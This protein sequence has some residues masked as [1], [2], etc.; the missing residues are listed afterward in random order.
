V[1]SDGLKQLINTVTNDRTDLWSYIS[2]YF[3]YIFSF[4]T[5]TQVA[6]VVPEHLMKL[7]MVRIVFHLLCKG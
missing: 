5:S 7:N 2:F 6:Q 1:V 3:I 4:E